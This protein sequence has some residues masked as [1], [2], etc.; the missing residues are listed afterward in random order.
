MSY[1]S[2]PFIFL[3]GEVD[4]RGSLEINI[5]ECDILNISD[6][7]ERILLNTFPSPKLIAY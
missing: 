1:V 6:T 5:H 7:L 3:L 4:L 2:L